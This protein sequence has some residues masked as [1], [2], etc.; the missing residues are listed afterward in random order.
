MGDLDALGDRLVAVGWFIPPY[1]SLGALARIASVLEVNPPEE[2]GALLEACL[3]GIY[4]PPSLAALVT[5]RYPLV[6]RVREYGGMIGESVEAHFLGLH[7]VAVAGL[8]PVIEGAALKIAA[9]EKLPKPERGGTQGVLASLAKHL[10]AKARKEN[11]G[12]PEE[13]L[14]MMNCFSNYAAEQL[15]VH[16]TKYPHDDGTNRHGIVHGAYSD[17]D[18]GRP[19]NFYK[20]ISALNFLCLCGSFS[21]GISWQRPVDT[22]KS[23]VLAAHYEKLGKVGKERP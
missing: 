21:G 19:L 14:S 12:A 1:V 7:H 6:P 5:E 11:L 9:D 15:Y 22:M 23:K 20:V 8:I 3:A 2:Q 16:S 10:A 18:F 13:I 17:A 4:S